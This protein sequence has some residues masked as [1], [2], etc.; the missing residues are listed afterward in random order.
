[1][2]PVL[3]LRNKSIDTVGGTDPHVMMK[4]MERL[5]PK[6]QHVGWR[7]GT[8]TVRELKRALAGGASILIGGDYEK[9]PHHYRRWTNN[10]N[11]NHEM[12]VKT[13]ETRVGGVDT[14][15]LYD[16]LGGGP[17][18]DPYD[19]EWIAFDQLFGPDKFT[20]RA[21]GGFVA[22]IVQN[23]EF[24]AMR[25]VFAK[26]TREV[27]VKM[28][29]P[30]YKRPTSAIAHHKKL[31]R[32]ENWRPNY[33]ITYNGW[34][35][36]EYKVEDE[37]FYGYINKLD[38]IESRTVQDDPRITATVDC[39]ALIEENA[40]LEADNA[41]L[42]AANNNLTATITAVQDVVCAE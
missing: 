38:I 20:W 8:W 13:I 22:G 18:R 39:T 23:K 3:E 5:W 21:A 6:G 29:T 33:G 7:Y 24:N 34:R 11:F 4:E 40:A 16:P 26:A 27:R 25:T 37:V 31:W 41:D 36:I 17:Q 35:L 14:T 12:M 42:T 1:M 19:G 30:V 2:H 10:D 15:F 28:G 9:L 32:S